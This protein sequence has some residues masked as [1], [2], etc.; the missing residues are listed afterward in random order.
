M[1]LLGAFQL[2]AHTMIQKII[3]GAETLVYYR[4]EI[5]IMVLC[6]IVLWSIGQPAKAFLDIS[7]LGVGVFLGFGR[8]GCYN[9]GCCH[10]RPSKIGVKYS[11]EHAQ[12]GFPFYFVGVK[13]FPIP[14]VESFF[15]FLTVIVGTWFVLH[16][17]PTGTALIWY[18]VF[19][20]GVRF[21]IEFFRGDPERPYW[22]GFS[23]AQWTTLGLFIFTAILSW[24]GWL[25]F[26]TVHFVAVA[27]LSVSML[28]LYFYRQQQTL[29]IFQ[30]TQ[31]SHVREIAIGLQGIEQI[32]H[33]QTLFQNNQVIPVAHTSLGLKI[34][35]GVV[36]YEKGNIVHYTLSAANL[37]NETGKKLIVN[38]KLA[39]KVGQLIQ[40]L[41]HQDQSF[42]VQEGQS[43]IY[44][45]IFEGKY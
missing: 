37:N 33:E 3:T 2:F 7:L 26:Y 30:L 43:G 41:R 25:P 40:I 9:V 19:Y 18:T 45:I 23:E 27:L 38:H 17:Y 44:H 21:V 6:S 36:P 13:I 35:T 29:P 20:G 34:S 32:K 14:L 28:G 15:V 16:N 42:Q 5:G 4:H 10:G 12:A 8:M 1:S 11:D 31:P 39:N 24:I 22:Y